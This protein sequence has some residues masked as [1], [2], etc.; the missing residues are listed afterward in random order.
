[1][2]SIRYGNGSYNAESVVK[3]TKEEYIAK[4]KAKAFKGMPESNAVAKLGEIWDLARAAV[5]L[6][7]AA[8]PAPIQAS[9]K[10]SKIIQTKDK[11]SGTVPP[12]GGGE[13][14]E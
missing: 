1:V 10:D 12:A 5:P 14:A 2:K 9:K 7:E 13:T 6:P 11:P 3:L 8:E 4:N